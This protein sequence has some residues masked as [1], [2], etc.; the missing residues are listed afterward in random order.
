R[1]CWRCSNRPRAC[2]I[3]K[4][5]GIIRPAWPC[6]KKPKGCPGPLC[7]IIFVC[8]RACRWAWPPWMPSPPMKP[9]CCRNGREEKLRMTTQVGNYRHVT[10]SWDDAVAGGLDPVARL[11]YRSNLLGSD[12]LIH[13]DGRGSTWAKLPE[14]E[15]LTRA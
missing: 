7:G 6:S 9:R 15:Q 8:N 11:V 12:G 3:W 10:D 2:A 4:W 1:R 13:N 5:P 14:S